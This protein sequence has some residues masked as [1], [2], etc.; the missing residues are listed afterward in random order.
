VS[1]IVNHFQQ[2]HQSSTLDRVSLNPQPLP[3]KVFLGY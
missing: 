3:P 1:G 2:V